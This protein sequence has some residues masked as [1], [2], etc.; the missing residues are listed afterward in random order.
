MQI[1][2]LWQILK[3]TFCKNVCLLTKI[4]TNRPQIKPINGPCFIW[5]VSKQYHKNDYLLT[6]YYLV[7]RSIIPCTCLSIKERFIVCHKNKAHLQLFMWI[8][9]H[10]KESWLDNHLLL[11][12]GSQ[13]ITFGG[14]V[15]V[16]TPGNSF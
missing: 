10:S 7:I 12:T 9:I 14:Q 3:L 15:I 11:S 16:R 2:K 6:Q 5:L 1:L 13:E 8:C 4:F